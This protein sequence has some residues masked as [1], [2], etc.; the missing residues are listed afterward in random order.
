MIF[1]VRLR[2]IIFRYITTRIGGVKRLENISV[3]ITD[4]IIKYYHCPTLKSVKLLALI[5][6]FFK[7]SSSPD[8]IPIQF[9]IFYGNYPK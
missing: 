4:K 5:V 9:R 7:I 6:S 2:E 1:G 3:L 8:V